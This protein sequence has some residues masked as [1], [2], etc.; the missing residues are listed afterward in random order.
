MDNENWFPEK[1]QLTHVVEHNDTHLE[2]L[3]N[4]NSPKESF[5]ELTSLI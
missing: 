5:L 4:E 3:I 2:V 1:F